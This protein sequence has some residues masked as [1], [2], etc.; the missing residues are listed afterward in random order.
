MHELKAEADFR[1]L[2]LGHLGELPPQQQA[3]AAFLLEH[4]GEVPFLSVPTIAQQTGASEA[5]V[6]R[7]AQRLGFDGFSELKA[8]LLEL[9]RERLAAPRA[10]V[11]NGEA[12][13]LSGVARLEQGN[14]QRLVERL[15]PADFRAAAAALF[16][17]DHVYLF[18]MG[19]SSLLSELAAYLMT[20]IGLRVTA[21]STRFSS[22]REQ[23]VALRASDLLFAFSFPPYSRQ[24]LDLLAE[25]AQRG[26]PTVVVTDRP[27]AP[28]AA[29]ARHVLAAPTDNMLLTNAVAA[30]TVL[31]NALVTEIAV[32]H[33]GRAV[34]AL[35]RINRILA[36][37]EDVLHGTT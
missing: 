15:S 10:L 22:P 16:K 34:D 8:A 33:Q 20:E 17:A 13:L 4:L 6:V 37:E 25:A 3:I 23:L 29:S 19:I 5:T 12:E 11:A 31:L 2:V 32:R 24:T 35:T 27:D 9:V 21:L 28:A 26:L 36:E 18:G 14:V 30:V 7:L 1:E